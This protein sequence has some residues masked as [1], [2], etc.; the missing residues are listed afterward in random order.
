MRLLAQ[1]TPRSVSLLRLRPPHHPPQC[2]EGVGESAN[3][4]AVR[5]VNYHAETQMTEATKVANMTP[6]ELRSMMQWAV[7]VGMFGYSMIL[8]LIVIV[9]RVLF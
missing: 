2:G 6:R 9:I 5:C 7:V 4:A 1:N 3:L 8:G